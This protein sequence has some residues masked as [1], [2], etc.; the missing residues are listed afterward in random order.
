[1]FN[2]I[3][4]QIAIFQHPPNYSIKSGLRSPRDNFRPGIA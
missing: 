1:W 2:F 4:K 3:F